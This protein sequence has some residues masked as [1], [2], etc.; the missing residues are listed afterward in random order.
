MNLD[1]RVYI[2]IYFFKQL[3]FRSGYL[4]AVRIE[5]FFLF[6]C[7]IL[8]KKLLILEILKN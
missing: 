8:L 3:K 6:I 4:K 1:V 5:I 2:Y 7:L